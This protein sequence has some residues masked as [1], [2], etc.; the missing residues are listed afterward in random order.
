MEL[1]RGSV[2][3]VTGAASGLGRALAGR[4]AA[5]GVR[6][7]LL[8]RDAPG[9]ERLATALSAEGAEVAA[10]VVDV[11]DPEACR[12]GVRAAVERFG[13]IDA[14]V[15]CAGLVRPGPF[16]EGRPEDEAHMVDVNLMG[17]IHL[18]KA[19]LPVLL[20]QDAGHL[21]HVASLAGRSPVP[22]EA[23]YCATKYGVRGFSLSLGLELRDTPVRVSVVCPD[24][25]E[26]PATAE[27][28]ASGGAPLSFSAPVLPVERVV[29]AVLRA[30]RTGRPEICVPAHRGFLA[31]FIELFPALRG[32]LLPLLERAGRRRLAERAGDALARG[33]R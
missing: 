30:L 18:S 16:R 5:R 17:T 22:G 4:L 32:P 15:H 20:A 21:V 11:R 10:R 28:A 6:L 13:R 25:F 14:A 12:E 8:D 1:E 2:A 19:V 33:A 7:A 29:D 24:T 3:L 26:S 9:L 31:A 27:E 23:V